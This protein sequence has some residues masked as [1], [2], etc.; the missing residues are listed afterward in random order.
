MIYLQ[1][2]YPDIIADKLSII[3]HHMDKIRNKTFIYIPDF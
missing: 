1:K 2:L 3:D